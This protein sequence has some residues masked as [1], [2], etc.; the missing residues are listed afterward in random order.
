VT[1][2]ATAPTCSSLR[3]RLGID[4]AGSASEIR[5]RLLLE[6]PGTWPDGAR[7]AAF[8]AALGTRAGS[9]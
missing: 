6:H 2:A 8:A 4:T 5:S 3:E 1:A 9:S 7:D